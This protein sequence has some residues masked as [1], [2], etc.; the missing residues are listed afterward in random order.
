MLYRDLTILMTALLSQTKDNLSFLKDFNSSNDLCNHKSSQTPKVI[1]PYSVSKLNLATLLC[2]LFLHVKFG[3]Q[4][5]DIFTKG[6]TGARI[7]Y[8][9]N[10]LSMINIYT[11][12]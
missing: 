7:N 1:A 5:G 9:Y 6:L 11:P 2:F 3:D 12:I 4:L 8:I 10:N